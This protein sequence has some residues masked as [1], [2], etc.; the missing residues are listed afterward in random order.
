MLCVLIYNF[1]CNFFFMERRGG[2]ER[3]LGWGYGGSVSREVVERLYG[4]L[5][6]GR[7]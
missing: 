5:L 6:A 4:G 2:G 1:F 3:I 7:G